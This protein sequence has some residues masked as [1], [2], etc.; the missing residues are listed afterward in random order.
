MLPHQLLIL[1]A[2]FILPAFA[3]E[4]VITKSATFSTNTNAAA[5]AAAASLFA[6]E[7][8][9]IVEA[10]PTLTGAALSSVLVEEEEA[11]ASA[12]DYG[13]Y[14]AYPSL[15]GTA[16]AAESAALASEEAA[17]ESAYPSLTGTAAAAESSAL[18]SEEAAYESAYPS[19]T[20][21]AAAAQS[22]AYASEDAAFAAAEESAYPSLTGTATASSSVTGTATT[23]PSITATAPEPGSAAYESEIAAAFHPL[24]YSFLTLPSGT[25]S[26]TGSAAESAAAEASYESAYSAAQ[27][28][29]PSLT[30]AAAA[31]QSAAAASLQSEEAVLVAAE[32]TYPALTGTAGAAYSAALASEEAAFYA[33]PSL[34]GTAGAAYSAALASEEAA[35]ASAYPSLTGTAGAAY[36]S[37][38]A[39]EEAFF[40]SASL[41][42][43]PA[44]TTDACGPAI[45]DPSVPDS[46][47]TPVSEVTSPAAYGV[48]CLN[49]TTSPNL[50]IN[51]SSCAVLIP[52]LCANQWQRPGE[53]VWLTASGCSLGSFLPPATFTGHA[54]WPSQ[55]QCEE[56]IYASMIE[57]CE[58]SG[59]GYNIAAVN[60]RVL[61]D[62]TGGGSGESVN[63]G[64][65]SY[66]VSAVQLRTL[67]DVK[68]CQWV[69]ATDYCQG[70]RC[71]PATYYQSKYMTSTPC[72][73]LGSAAPS[74]VPLRR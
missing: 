68:D 49:D 5:A 66:L 56:L 31:A 36:S 16:A 40:A 60:L 23:S 65:G 30:G 18:A 15:T 67:S 25:G 34:T 59:V 28:Q 27:T 48:Q 72:G 58:Y 73:A 9:A 29:Y 63:V 13:I 46:C 6:A 2:P 12:S 22:A 8:A 50:A 45:P 70:N 7:S 52:E 24:Q 57:S 1:L 54:P 4:G 20:G 62:N 42:A 32:S 17:F 39:S 41:T 44:N 53:W 71:Y 37:A 55:A 64:Y 61:P 35:F 10:Y 51:I 33:Y 3:Q 69:P 38:L 74:F 26:A 14:G 47:D 11:I 19:L 43:L 21:T